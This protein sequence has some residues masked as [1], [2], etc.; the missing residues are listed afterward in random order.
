[1]LHSQRPGVH[2]RDCVGD[3]RVNYLVQTRVTEGLPLAAHIHQWTGENKTQD[4]VGAQRRFLKT[5]RW[6][7]SKSVDSKTT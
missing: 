1:M 7:D 2:I 4:F 6:A 3:T 5:Q